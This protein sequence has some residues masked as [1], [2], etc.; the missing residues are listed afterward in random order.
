MLQ[1]QSTK[2]R[3]RSESI[4]ITT[5][6]RIRARAGGTMCAEGKSD[7]HH[8][9]QHPVILTAHAGSDLQL[10]PVIHR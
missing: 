9:Q 10:S 6:P 5:E 2:S 1:D 7:Q 3:P 8:S 4:A